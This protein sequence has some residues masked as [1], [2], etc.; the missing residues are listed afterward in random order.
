MKSFSLALSQDK[1]SQL[2]AIA[3]DRGQTIE[4]LVSSIVNQH[5][6]NSNKITRF[7]AKRGPKK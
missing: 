3:K 7:A 1:C 5:L 2:E 6:L 4:E